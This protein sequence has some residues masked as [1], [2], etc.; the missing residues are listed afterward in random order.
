MENC[1]LAAGLCLLWSCTLE[2][3][4][5][6][7]TI[8]IVC[9]VQ[10]GLVLPQSSTSQS[11]QFDINRTHWDVAGDNHNSE[12]K[13]GYA[14]LR[15][16]TGWLD[17]IELCKLLNSSNRIMTIQLLQT[18]LPIPFRHFWIFDSHTPVTIVVVIDL[19]DSM[20]LVSVCEVSG[21]RR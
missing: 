14:R 18:G 4:E 5:V 11:M 13:S 9:N 7:K 15:A 20:L 3:G 10:I 12:G 16:S 6:S 8:K 17:S 21:S 2:R 1:F 19:G